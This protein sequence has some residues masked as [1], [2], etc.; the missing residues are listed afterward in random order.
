MQYRKI[1]NIVIFVNVAIIVEVSN[2][3]N[4]NNDYD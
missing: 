3:I 4:D 2:G 1:V